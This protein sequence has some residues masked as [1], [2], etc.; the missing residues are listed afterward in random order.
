MHPIIVM[1]PTP[2][3]FPETLFPMA[4]YKNEC[5][6]RQQEIEDSLRANL[7]YNL[8]SEIGIK[9]SLYSSQYI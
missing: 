8:F 4:V 6:C 2:L 7:L 5:L 3:H 9:S 1:I